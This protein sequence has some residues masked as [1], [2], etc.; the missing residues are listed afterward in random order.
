[1]KVRNERECALSKET[2]KEKNTLKIK[3]NVLFPKLDN[4]LVGMLIVII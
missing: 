2:K 4:Y 1:M 3:E